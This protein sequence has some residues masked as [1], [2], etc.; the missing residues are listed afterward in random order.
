MVVWLTSFIAGPKPVRQ[1]NPVMPTSPIAMPTGTRSSINANRQTKPTIATISLFT[2]LLRRLD[3]GVV[4]FFRMKD[5]PIGSDCD[6]QYGRGVARPRDGEKRPG[7]KLQV[8][9]QDIVAPGGAH[10]VEQGDGLHGDDEQQHRGRE[11]VD[12]PLIFRR[13]VGPD[14]VDRDVRSAIAGRGDAPEYQNA[15][16]Q[17][18]EVVVVWNGQAE[19]LAHEDGDEG[20]HGDNADE[21]RGDQL[22]PV[23]ETVLP[24]PPPRGKV[25]RRAR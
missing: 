1:P 16:Q 23:E 21:R 11:D 12:P 19:E 15:Q 8:V 6:Q 18:T 2:Q 4:N 5:E 7:R 3:F 22:D 10:L 17:P 13:N 9:G 14:E 25:A 24:L 20:I